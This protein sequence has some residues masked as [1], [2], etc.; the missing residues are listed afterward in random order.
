MKAD[1]EKQVGDVEKRWQELS[2]KAKAAAK[3]LKKEQ[4]QAWAADAK[5]VTEG[6]Q[7]VKSAVAGEPATAKEKLGAVV[8][9]L[10]K[11]DA[12]LAAAAMPAKPVAK[13]PAPKKK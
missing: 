7:A 5:A 8:A 11:W 1:V 10:D 4:Q 13:T 9:T 3:K 2:G 6:L 12:Q